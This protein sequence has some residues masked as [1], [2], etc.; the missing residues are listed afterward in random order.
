MPGKIET[1][2]IR[3][4]TWRSIHHLY[5]SFNNLPT[6]TYRQFSLHNKTFEHLRIQLL[7]WSVVWF[8]GN[9]L[10]QWLLQKNK[11]FCRLHSVFCKNVQLNIKMMEARLTYTVLPF[12]ISTFGFLLLI[13]SAGWHFDHI[14]TCD[15]L[16]KLIVI[17]VPVILILLALLLTP[18]MQIRKVELVNLSTN[19]QE[20]RCGSHDRLRQTKAYVGY[21]LLL[22]TV[23]KKICVNISLTSV[24]EYVCSVAY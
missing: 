16:S 14:T 21:F 5:F 24:H 19:M 2:H 17:S 6:H 15:P 18:N 4:L 8:W 20:T 3:I 23:Y 11:I 10:L 1:L 12:S 7:W 13:L 22:S 9:K